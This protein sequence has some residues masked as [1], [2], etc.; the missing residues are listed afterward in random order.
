MCLAG[1]YTGQKRNIVMPL[2]L[3][4]E[5]HLAKVENVLG[6]EN[7]EL[8]IVASRKAANTIRAT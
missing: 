4:E 3:L 2:V 7:S 1:V 6:R 8:L 5:S